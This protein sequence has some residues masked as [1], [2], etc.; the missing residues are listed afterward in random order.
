M[1]AQACYPKMGRMRQEDSFE[2]EANLSYR[3]NF[4][5]AQAPKQNPVLVN[6]TKIF[7]NQIPKTTYYYQM[8]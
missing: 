4:R 5:P 7:P 2:F 1:V 8:V 3:V 6:E